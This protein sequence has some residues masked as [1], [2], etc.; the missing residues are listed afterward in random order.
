MSSNNEWDPLKTVIVGIADNAT[1]P[2]IS[3]SVRTVNY[4]DVTDLSTIECGP[5]PK[6]V[7]EEANEDL[8]ILCDF[9]RKEHIKVLRPEANHPEYYNY[10]PRDTVL[11]HDEL[12]L[13]TPTAL[14]ER[15]H[16]WTSSA[17][18]LN[19]VTVAPIPNNDTLY[20]SACIGNPDILALNEIDPCFDAANIIRA[21]DDLYYL[22][23]NT[24]NKKGAE[25]LRSLGKTV[26]TIENVYSYIHIDST[27]AFL[28]EGLMLLNPKRINNVKEQLP[29]SL[30]NWDV[31][32]ASEPVDIGH[33]PGI[34]NASTWIN[35]NL[36]SINPSLVVLE[37]HQHN[38][39]IKL[40]KYG[41]ESAMLPM[42][43]ARTLGGCFHCVTLDLDR[44]HK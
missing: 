37:E 41:I 27:I 22:V 21:N 2:P 35:V 15:R 4:A 18:Y 24:G 6:Q 25:Y 44:D 36:L 16:E 1:R 19:I 8:E 12:V 29:K 28:R 39:R 32:W 7:I 5:Y 17:K 20:N 38:L 42:R 3:T 43:H 14:A 40:E 10:C 26:H 23:S 30:H 34:C 13:A 9:L 33:Y 11:I 31:I